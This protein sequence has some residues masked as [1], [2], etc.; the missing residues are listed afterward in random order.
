MTLKSIASVSLILLAN[1]LFAQNNYVVKPENSELIWVGE[2]VTGSHEGTISV[3]EGFV[4]VDA[5]KITKGALTIDMSTI[6]V[7]DI[8]SESG[9][10]KLKKHLDSPDFFSVEKFPTSSLLLEKVEHEEGNRYIL[11]GTLSIKGYSEKVTINAIVKTE[12][13]NIAIVGETK[14]DRTKFKIQYG[15]GSFFDNLGDKA[16]D[17][18]FTVKFK[19]GAVK[20]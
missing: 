14:I 12:G 1:L 17:D 6:K 11:Y 18:Y 3:K 9:K 5:G 16:I 2:K 7:T 13:D 20:S 19:V 10:A 15:S 8:N 4:T